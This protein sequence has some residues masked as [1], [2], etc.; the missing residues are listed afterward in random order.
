MSNET[1]NNE[2]NDDNKQRTLSEEQ[3][4]E[5]IHVVCRDGVTALKTH[6]DEVVGRA[7]IHEIFGPVFIFTVTDDANDKYECGFLLQELIKKFQADTDPSVWMASF[8]V[9]MMR[10]KGG[11]PLPTPPASEEE[12]KAIIERLIVGPCMASVKEEFAPEEVYAG[13]E[14]HQEHGPVF[15]TGFPSIADGNNVCAFKIDLLLMH[16]LLNRDPAELL[17]DGLYKIR[18][19]HGI[20]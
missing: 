5:L 2:I 1:G 4:N 19:E 11:K 18:E 10:T 20:E 9:E 7:V 16:V 3:W 17:L 13:L 6:Y 15:E 14:W 12:A 8:F